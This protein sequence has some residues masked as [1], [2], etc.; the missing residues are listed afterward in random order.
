MF[1]TFLRIPRAGAALEPSV[2]IFLEREA[3]RSIKCANYSSG[4]LNTAGTLFSLP[5]D[6]VYCRWDPVY[7]ALGPGLLFLGPGLFTLGPG[8]LCDIY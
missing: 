2:L 7:C 1:F 5:W 6:P 4:D 8:L 3:S